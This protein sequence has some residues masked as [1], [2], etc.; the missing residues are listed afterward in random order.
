M[1]DEFLFLYQSNTTIQ[2]SD[3]SGSISS[4]DLLSTDGGLAAGPIGSNQITGFDPNQVLSNNSNNG[5]IS[6]YLITFSITGLDGVVTGVTGA[7]VPLFQYGPGVLEMFITF[8][9]STLINFMDIAITGGGATGVS[10][11]LLGSADFTKVDDTYNNLFHSGSYT[12]DGSSGFFDIWKNCGEGAGKALEISFNASFDTNIFTSD[13]DYDPIAETFYVSSTHDGSG[14]MGIPEPASLALIG[15]GLL[16]LG[17]V[18]RR[19]TV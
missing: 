14:T 18:R 19:K 11:V 10:T 17:A 9:G 16:G 15:V 3:S 7:G 12:C 4:G 5:L 1:K 8:D 6:N 2:D 13:F